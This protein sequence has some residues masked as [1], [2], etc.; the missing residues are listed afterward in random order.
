MNHAKQ[1]K[2]GIKFLAK[3][4]RVLRGL[5]KQAG[6]LELKPGLSQDLFL[7]LARTIIFQQLHAKAASKILG[8]L[9]NL[10]PGKKMTP[11]RLLQKSNRLLRQAGLSQN[12][13]LA[14]QDLATKH[15]QGL[16]PTK[17]QLSGLTDLEIIDRL[18]QIRGIGPWTVHMLLIFRLGRLDVLPTGDFGVR[19]GFRLA[20]KKRKMPTPKELET[21][22]EGWKPYRSLAALYLWRVVDLQNGTDSTGWN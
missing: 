5:I 3:R 14:L 12:K 15:S 2:V 11:Q 13:M 21:F 8:R 7:P 1:I 9:Q 22:G 19:N 17:K 20:Y 18:T 10:F 16:V 6:P 4:D